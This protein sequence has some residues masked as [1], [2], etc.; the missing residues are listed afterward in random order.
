MINQ[1]LCCI[2]VH[3]PKNAGTSVERYLSDPRVV[4]D[5][6]LNTFLGGDH[7]HYTLA[8]LKSELSE[9]IFNNYFK[10]TI[11]RNPWD[12]M[13]SLYEYCV[14]GGRNN[15]LWVGCDFRTFCRKFKANSLLVHTQHS[16]K[17]EIYSAHL[18]KQHEFISKDIDFVLRYEN[19]SGDF[20][21]VAARLKLEVPFLPKTN[22]SVR[23]P[24]REYYDDVLKDLVRDIFIEDIRVFS[25]T[26]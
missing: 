25:Y 21:R 15:E 10:F 24:Y 22:N 20:K 6:S 17:G 7:T 9:D 18:L 8:E 14:S 3:I 26:F 16:F 2:F 23:R 5:P 1:S 4:G 11:V 12:R 19:L 13:V